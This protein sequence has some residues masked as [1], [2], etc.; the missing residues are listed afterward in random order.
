MKRAIFLLGLCSALLLPAG[1][2]ADLPGVSQEVRDR[3][4]EERMRAEA[5]ARIASVMV[6]EAVG[7]VQFVFEIAGPGTCEYT[8]RGPKR[9]PKSGDDPGPVVAKNRL[10]AEGADK[11]VL[12]DKAVIASEV[13]ENADGRY[14]LE[15]LC[16][17]KPVEQTNFGPKETEEVKEVHIKRSFLLHH[18]SIYRVSN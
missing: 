9:G 10:T 6:Q 18:E 15:A 11:H 5:E 12:K 14:H 13:K 8:L 16:R 1:A 4:F 2:F 17:V 7:G 3:M